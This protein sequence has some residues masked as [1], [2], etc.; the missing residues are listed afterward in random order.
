MRIY[1]RAGIPTCWIVN[2][3]DGQ[4]EVYTEPSGPAVDAKYGRRD[5][6]RAGERVTLLLEGQPLESIAVSDVL[7]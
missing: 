3:L 1:A 7:V 2:L 4:L 5:V 6:Y